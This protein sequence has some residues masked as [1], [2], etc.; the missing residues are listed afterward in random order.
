MSLTYQQL[1][2]TLSYEQEDI[3]A[4]WID[5]ALETH[6]ALAHYQTED[7]ATYFLIITQKNKTLI[8]MATQEKETCAT[9]ASNPYAAQI[10]LEHT[11]RTLFEQKKNVDCSGFS[12]YKKPFCEHFIKRI[13]YVM[14]NRVAGELVPVSYSESDESFFSAITNNI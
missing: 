7:E 3:K 1:K 5:L 12:F 13:F 10:S 8:V 2:R 9:L 11:K 14:Q 6:V 4:T